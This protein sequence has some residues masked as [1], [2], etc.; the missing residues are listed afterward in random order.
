MRD[1]RCTAEHGHP[2]TLLQGAGRAW[3]AG[4]V[5][6]VPGTT[7]SALVSRHPGSFEVVDRVIR[8]STTSVGAPD[9]ITDTH[10]RTLCHQI[11]TGAHD[12]YL[13]ALRDA[14]TAG[15]ARE[16]V[17]AAIDARSRAVR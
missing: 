13:G 3:R 2:A 1:I 15:P 17:L 14:E 4:D 6:S 7:A 16:S 10:W 5:R 8:G 9:G 11:Q 12:Q